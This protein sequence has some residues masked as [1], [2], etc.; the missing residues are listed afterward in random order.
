MSAE[1][2]NDE[3]RAAMTED[4]YQKY[5]RLQ[6]EAHPERYITPFFDDAPGPKSL[7]RRAYKAIRNSGAVL[8]A[9][10]VYG[11]LTVPPAWFAV[12]ATVSLVVGLAFFY[13]IAMIEVPE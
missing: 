5:M 6:R 12:I 8:L 2:L 7:T 10:L 4:P 13:A 9:S 11:T 3:I 1:E